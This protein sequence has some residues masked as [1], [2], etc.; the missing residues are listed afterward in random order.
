MRG[1]SDLKQYF[2]AIIV[3]LLTRMQTSKTDKY[4]YLFVHFLLFSMAIN[5]DGLSPDYVA[6]AVEEVQ[7]GCVAMIIFPGKR[8]DGHYSLWAQILS[9]FVVPQVPKVPTKDRKIAAVGL[10]RLLTQSQIM[11]REPAV[12]QW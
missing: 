5:V 8:A 12:Q 3:T 2:R 10:T 11:L 4:I 7:P 9:N 1:R 6:G